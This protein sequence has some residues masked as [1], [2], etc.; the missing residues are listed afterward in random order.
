MRFTTYQDKIFNKINY[1]NNSLVIDARAGSGKTTTGVFAASSIP[2][3]R[4]V[5]YVAFNKHNVEELKKKLPS[6]VACYTLHAMGLS[7]LT[8]YRRGAQPTLTKTKFRTILRKIVQSTDNDALDKAIFESVKELCDKARMTLAKPSNFDWVI[9]NFGVF[10]PVYRVI[11][12]TDMSDPAGYSAELTDYMKWAAE[13]A[14]GESVKIFK[15]SGEIDYTDMV[16]L[17]NALNLVLP[18]KDVLFVDEAQD[19]NSAQ[20]GLVLKAT[21]NGG[22]IVALGDEFQAIQGFAGAANDSIDRIATIK[23]ADR[24]PLPICFRCPQSH[25]SLAQKIVP[26]ILW[27][28]DADEGCIAEVN[29]DSMMSLVKQGDMVICKHNAPLIKGALELI[30]RG[31]PAKVRGRDVSG[32]LAAYA[33]DV[34]AVKISGCENFR[35]CFMGKI[36]AVCN[37]EVSLAD[38]EKDRIDAAMDRAECMRVIVESRPEIGSIEQ[39]VG[40]IDR[41]FSDDEGAAMFSSVHRAKGAE[42]ERVFVMNASGFVVDYKEEA[43]GW[44]SQQLMNL[45]Y[46]ALTRAKREMYFGITA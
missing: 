28:D 31:M 20:I 9:N 24:L 22:Y 41:I 32:A 29:N 26:D 36:D 30:K 21:A 38:G 43:D 34:D 37:A 13:Y 39:L 14:M 42:G 19:L 4:K 16:Y 12:R 8:A 3:K 45:R 46:V 15:E 7:A 17:P 10:D 40:V 6:R 44:R 25:V 23:S 27:R 18:Q 2:A 5:A 33:R 35:S 1:L 11:A